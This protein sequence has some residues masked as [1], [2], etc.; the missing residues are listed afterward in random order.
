MDS[1]TMEIEKDKRDE[2]NHV[3]EMGRTDSHRVHRDRP[4]DIRE[5]R[6]S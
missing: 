2:Q 4:H 1:F 5:L 3:Q 6:V